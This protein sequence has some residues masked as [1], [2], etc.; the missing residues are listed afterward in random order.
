MLNLFPTN[1]KKIRLEKN[2]HL[3]EQNILVW[4]KSGSMLHE[5]N[6]TPHVH[7]KKLDFLKKYLDKP[8]FET[9]YL[10]VWTSRASLVF[11]QLLALARP[12]CALNTFSVPV[13]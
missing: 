12:Q 4:K 3:L 11:H 7:T 13:S 8:N 6:D 1:C 9:D 10:H 2:I 5:K